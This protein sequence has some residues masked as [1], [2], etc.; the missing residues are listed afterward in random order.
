MA[1]KIACKACG[2]SG[3]YHGFAEPRGVGVICRASMTKHRENSMTIHRA[4]AS[5]RGGRSGFLWGSANS[6]MK[7]F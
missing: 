3:V 5:Q 4:E 2:S 7:T 1:T 6:N